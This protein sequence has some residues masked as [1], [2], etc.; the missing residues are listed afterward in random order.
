MNKNNMIHSGKFPSITCGC[1][2]M[3]RPREELSSQGLYL[4][5]YALFIPLHGT[6]H[7]LM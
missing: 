1:F 2:Y 3:K 5:I 7:R 4:K 6:L